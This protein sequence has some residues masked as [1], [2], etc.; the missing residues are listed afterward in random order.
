MIIR[1]RSKDGNFRFDLQPSDDVSILRDKILSTAQDA[2]PSSINISNKPRGNEIKIDRLKGRTLKDLGLN[3]GDLIFATYQSNPASSSSNTASI[4]ATGTTNVVDS[5][6]TAKRPWELVK[7][8]SVDS[9]WRARDGKIPRGRDAQFCKHGAKGMCDYCMPLEPYDAGY[10]KE[11]NIKYLSY[12]AYLRKISPK[13]TGSASSFLPPLSPLSYKVKVPCPTGS[14]ASWPAGICTACQP[15][16][17]TLQSQPFRMVDHL[18]IASVDIVDRFLQAWRMSGLQRFGWLIGRYEPY[19]KVPM[20]VKAVVEAIYEP[21]QQ[22]ELDGLT[23]AWPWEDEKRIRDLSAAAS[24]PLTVVGY[25]FTD[26]T[27]TP[28]DRTKNIYKRHPQSFFI[29][30]LEAIFA[31]KLQH[32]NPTASKSSP[33]GLFGS[34][35]V[36][37]VLT[38]TEDGQIDIS[39]YQ[40]SE[41]AV[42]MV[43]A[44]MIEA[45]IDPGIVRVKEEDRSEDSARYLPDVFFSYK[46]EYGLEVKKSAKPC[47]PVEYLLV[48]V[49]HG[50]PQNPSPIFNSTQFKIE[51]R[52]G[53]EDQTLNNVMSQLLALGAPDIH[54]SRTAKPGEAHKRMELA[55]WLS[56]WHLIAFLGTTQLISEEDLKLMMRTLSNPRIFDDISLLDPV[57]NCDS[58]ET[59][60]T[61]TRESA[62]ARPS[63]SAPSFGGQ[64]DDDIPPEVFD[65]IAAESAA[66]GSNGGG[67]GSSSGIR[68]CPHCTFENTHGGSDCEVCG[69]PL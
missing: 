34:R 3:H 50:F 57:L 30:S 58:W 11:N 48:N 4:V 49:T 63:S 35:L 45:S 27:P 32:D 36:T 28:E 33:S 8:D 47:F 37:A 13:Q 6:D 1:I 43:D 15:S 54:D 5:T 64:M 39:A 46:N 20:G 14:H 44:D 60:M 19:D 22:G 55:R 26:L 59:L 67:L 23:L 9:Y 16:T 61:F 31:A 2:D 18:E 25:I 10:Q 62:P 24:V 69:L 65:Q 56:D 42:A 38:A 21:L 17:I 29:S 7:E 51:N 40:V 53:M 68:I 41:Q 12:H 52:P 66:A